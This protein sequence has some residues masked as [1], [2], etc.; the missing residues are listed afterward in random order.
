MSHSIFLNA[1][2]YMTRKFLEIYSRKNT[3]INNKV[4]RQSKI[5]SLFF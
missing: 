3:L 1:V 4:N 2:F 5:N